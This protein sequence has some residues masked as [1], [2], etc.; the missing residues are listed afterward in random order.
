[1]TPSDD[2]LRWLLRRELHAEAARLASSQ[3]GLRQIR[4]RLGSRSSF[5]RWWGGVRVDAQRYGLHTRHLLA[6]G[7]DALLRSARFVAGRPS[8]RGGEERDGVHRGIVW[9][10]PVVALAAVCIFAGTAAAVPGVRHA[11]TTIGSSGSGNTTSVNGQGG[12]GGGSGAG[13]GVRQGNGNSPPGQGGGT[14]TTASPSP[15][16]TCEPATRTVPSAKPSGTRSGSATATPTRTPSTGPASATPTVTP[17]VTPTDST[18]PGSPT[19]TSS[20]TWR[21]HHPHARTSTSTS[22]STHLSDVRPCPGPTPPEKGTAASNGAFQ[23][24]TA[25]PAP[26]VSEAPAA[27]TPSSTAP[28]SPTVSSTPAG[29]ASSAPATA[30]SASATARSASA[31]ASP[32]RD[33]R[34]GSPW[35]KGFGKA[36]SCRHHHQLHC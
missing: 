32:S 22:T 27:R 17:T 1:M 35:S 36:R 11:I 18:E 25:V 29:T 6:E 26:T 13:T 19:P 30:S 21:R 8:G 3:D 9:L 5:T 15:T 34:S 33:D 12:S 14:S 20:P 2:D 4:G 23:L 16:S 24:H 31:T 28:A 10:R 7:A